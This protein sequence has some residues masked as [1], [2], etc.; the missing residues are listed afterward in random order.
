MENENKRLTKLSKFISLVL[1]HDPSAAGLSLDEHGWADTGELIAGMC[2]AGKP[3]DLPTLE[4]IVA[5][6][7]KQRYTLTEDRKL[8]RANQGHSVPV[9]LELEPIEPPRTLL[10][11]TADRFAAA[12]GREGLRRMS[13]QYVHLSADLE[14][15]RK[16]GARHGNCIIYEV[17]AAGMHRDGFRFYRSA[18]GVWLTDAVPPVYLRRI[19]G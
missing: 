2:A 19:E 8:I 6:D 18:N 11:G 17:D 10:H 15:A 12:I 9:D 7:E 5:E 1:R 13:R 14:T 16:V 4:R 3:I